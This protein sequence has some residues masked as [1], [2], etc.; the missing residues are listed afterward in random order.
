MCAVISCISNQYLFCYIRIWPKH[1]PRNNPC[2][3]YKSGWRF[4]GHFIRN[5]ILQFSL[6]D[7]SLFY[8]PK[9]EKFVIL[10][11][12]QGVQ[13]PYTLAPPRLQSILQGEC[14]KCVCVCVSWF[15][16]RF[17]L[18]QGEQA[19][20]SGDLL[21]TFCQRCSGPTGCRSLLEGYSQYSGLRSV[22]RTD[23]ASLEDLAVSK[24]LTAFD[25]EFD[26]VTA[27]LA[28]IWSKLTPEVSVTWFFVSDASS[29]HMPLLNG[30]LQ[31]LTSCFSTAQWRHTGC[32][33]STQMNIKIIQNRYQVTSHSLAVCLIIQHILLVT[34]FV[35]DHFK[36][37]NTLLQL[38]HVARFHK[39]AKQVSIP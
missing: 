32:S 22:A 2:K 23:G 17:G 13:Y 18:K 37:T 3:V 7:L 25:G 20:V 35:T 15:L 21:H 19:L 28:E 26:S 29:S 4:S 8:R 1:A 14:P 11:V 33:G 31:V 12:V 34:S 27:N 24:C 38:F 6:S 5:P 30:F 10:Q 9:P 39:M 16:F 36:W